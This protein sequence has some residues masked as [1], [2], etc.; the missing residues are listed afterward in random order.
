[1]AVLK[2]FKKFIREYR[3]IGIS[4]GFVVAIAASNFIQSVINDIVLPI[5]RALFSSESVKWEDMILPIGS[6]NIRI[7][8]F[9]SASLSLLFIM[10]FLYIFID[11]ILHWKP[12]KS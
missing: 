7:G 8:S 1:M 6:V 2:D 9:L 10:V 3:I 4:I 12:K 5:I 11:K